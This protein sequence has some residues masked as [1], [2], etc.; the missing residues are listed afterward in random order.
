ML[1]NPYDGRL[2]FLNAPYEPGQKVAG[3]LIERRIGRGAYGTVYLARDDLIARHVALKVIRTPG[4]AET[5]D[6]ERALREARAVGRL[7]S[8]NIV[9]LHRVHPL[10]DEAGWLFEMEYVEG[11]SLKQLLDREPALPPERAVAIMRDM[12]HALQA[13]HA[14]GIVHGDIKPGNVLLTASGDA[15]LADF[16]LARMRDEAS[17]SL[18]GGAPVGTPS[19]MAPEVIMGESPDYASDLWS[20]GIVL[21]RMLAGRLPFRAQTFND[22]FFSVQNSAPHPLPAKVPRWLHAVVLKLLHKAP[23]D[24]PPS[25]GDVLAALDEAVEVEAPPAPAAAPGL[26]A[27]PVLFGRERELDRL[28]GLLG[29]VASGR[30]ASV[31]VSGDMGIGKTAL[32]QAVAPAAAEHGFRWIEATATPIDGLL[33]PLVRAA[34]FTLQGE[35]VTRFDAL[36]EK[37]ARGVSAQLLRDLLEEKVDVNLQTRQQ[38]AWALE[39]LFLGL[40]TERPLALV[41]EDAHQ[42]DAEDVKLLRE[43]ARRLPG[44]RVFLAITFRTHAT[45]SSASETT[46]VAGFH[47]LASVRD[48]E[49]FDLRP[50]EN[51]A[52]YRILEQHTDGI[53]IASPIARRVIDLSHGNPLFAGE[54]LRHLEATGAVQLSGSVVREGPSWDRAELPGR[55]RELVARRLAGLTDDQRALIDAAA[56]DGRVFDAE[57]LAALL[58]LPVL[59][60]LRDLQRLFRE[61]RLVEPHGDAFRFPSTVVQEVVYLELAPALRRA[62]HEQLA[63]HLEARETPVDPERLGMHWLA[64]KQKDRARPWLLR[65]ARA[66]ADRQENQRVIELCARAGLAAGRIGPGDV[67]EHADVLVRLAQALARRGRHDEMDRIYD[68]LLAS[69]DVE[70]RRRCVVAAAWSRYFARGA[71]AVDVPALEE[72]AQAL[73]PC[74]ELGEARYVLGLVARMGGELEAARRWFESADEAFQQLGLRGR[75]SSAVNAL[76]SVAQREARLEEAQRLY[77]DAA[78]IATS[79]G[80]RVNAAV[81]EVNVAIIALNRG[82]LD[83]LADS[84]ARSVRT[85]TLEGALHQSAY[86]NVILAQARYAG[87]DVQG[88]E[89]AIDAAEDALQDTKSLPALSAARLE[90][91]QLALARGDVAAARSSLEDARAA[92]RQTGNVLH[93]AQAAALRSQVECLVGDAEAAV[94]AAAEAFEIA[95]GADHAAALRE[96]LPFVAEAALFGMPAGALRAEPPPAE[97]ETGRVLD[98]VWSAA[99]AVAGKDP[100]PLERAAKLVADRPPGMRRSAWE[101]FGLWLEARALRMR[102]RGTEARAPA[103]RALEAAHALGHVWYQAGL[104]R[105]LAELGDHASRDRCGELIERIAEGMGDA[106]ERRRLESA[107]S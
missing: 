53:R 21:F 36:L 29:E 27:P 96:P 100:V 46:G 73:P 32:L 95:G 60:V 91:A 26:P 31:L 71:D 4:G 74:Q 75:H 58:E 1:A 106:D 87:G 92:A 64:A 70:H 40:A 14:A 77:A 59:R 66:A 2:V 18:G 98:A 7:N 83:G 34:N 45:D 104:S 3:L 78:R 30:G 84:L 42:A 6:Y 24:R 49:H 90:R 85:L 44:A 19:Y 13:A 101:I 94:S 20:A 17:L 65:A 22:L 68:V 69:D 47:E 56:V 28:R 86:A 51:E 89:R 37:I 54:M 63:R 72:A 52:V 102:G 48:I 9:T 107:W 15:K 10:D 61:T 105:F 43:L 62:M 23:R 82:E 76:A 103:E 80:W 11:G 79:V 67:A 8:P 16:G 93:L 33:R 25:P 99:R 35:G 57:A 5:H 39:Q 12:L 97:D 41:V 88:A 50:L 38:I 81:S 55:F